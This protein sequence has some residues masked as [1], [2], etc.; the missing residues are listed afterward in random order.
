MNWRILSIIAAFLIVSVSIIRY[1]SR[2]PSVPYQEPEVDTLIVGT[3]AEYPPLAFVENDQIVGL[4]I[5]VIKEVVKRLNKNISFKDMSFSALIPEL[6]IGSIHAIAG[7]ITPSEERS[8]RVF[9]TTPH[10][11]DDPL[12][13]VQRPGASPISRGEQLVGKKLIV[14]QGYTADDYAST[15]ADAEVM[16]ISSPLV[17]TGLLALQSG[18]AD[19]YIAARSAL[20]PFFAKQKTNHV[21]TPI[22]GTA[23]TYALAVSKKYPN[24]YTSIQAVITQ[25][26]QDGSIEKIKKSWNLS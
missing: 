18:K 2:R 15:I 16:R 10:L 11:T 3:N 17:S 25:M 8:K 13:A 23:E 4:D 14:N 22:E 1:V 20:M 6:Q 7:G 26:M 9:F 12:M 19:V 24:L 21:S 5:D